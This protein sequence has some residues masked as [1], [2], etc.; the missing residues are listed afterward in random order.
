MRQ[1]G[2]IWEAECAINCA[3]AS[4]HL[5]PLQQWNVLGMIDE[6]KVLFLDLNGGGCVSQYLDRVTLFE[7]VLAAQPQSPVRPGTASSVLDC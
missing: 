7:I 1:D 5:K 3:R 6:V 4:A 2:F